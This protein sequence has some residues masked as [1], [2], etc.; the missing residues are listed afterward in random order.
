MIFTTDPYFTLG[1][2]PIVCISPSKK[3][4]GIITLLILLFRVLL[5]TTAAPRVVRLDS[6]SR[7]TSRTTADRYVYQIRITRFH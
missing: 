1:K 4:G 5:A 7:T 2:T 6:G 3:I